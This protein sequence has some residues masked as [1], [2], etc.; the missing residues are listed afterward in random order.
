ML[1]FNRNNL[2]LGISQVMKRVE[3]FLI[4][5]QS[6]VQKSLLRDRDVLRTLLNIYDII[7]CEMFHKDLSMSLS[8]INF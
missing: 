6:Y 4:T 3:N 7:F 5:T 2:V 1:R 8:V